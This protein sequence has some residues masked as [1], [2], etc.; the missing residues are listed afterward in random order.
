MNKIIFFLLKFKMTIIVLMLIVILGFIL[1]WEVSKG[2]IN[3]SMIDYNK[4]NP[5][6]LVTDWNA[7]IKRDKI[8]KISKWQRENLFKWDKIRTL[9]K[10]T[11]T[12]FWPDW[13]ITRLWERS[14][15]NIT[16]LNLNKDTTSNIKFDIGSWKSWSNIVRYMDNSTFTETYDNERL[17][18]TVRWTIFEINVDRDYVHSVNHSVVINDVANNKDYEVPEWKIR[19][20]TWTL[21]FLTDKSLENAWEN[22][23]KKEDVI[24][25]NSLLIEWRKKIDSTV[26]DLKLKESINDLIDW[27]TQDIWWIKAVLN[28]SLNDNSKKELNKFFLNLYQN[29]N[30][31]PNNS[32]TIQLKANLRDEIINSS[33]DK[34]R[35][36]YINDFLRLNLFDY[37]DSINNNFSDSQN[38][39][40]NYINTYA[41]KNLDKQYLRSV[42]KSIPEDK[43]KQ[44]NDIF[45]N[46]NSPV[47][48]IINELQ[49]PEL[50]EKADE[51]VNTLKKKA[52]DTKNI[53]DK[54]ATEAKDSLINIFKNKNE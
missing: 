33:N 29:I 30:N 10:T 51:D 36:R 21:D 25:I 45:E 52:L 4:V 27:K 28:N 14:S 6:I 5:Y 17:A 11:A 13:S 37:I 41:Q 23:N 43:L 31:I 34:D 47:K 48:N 19:K 22:W 32:W 8:I 53:I 54:K 15:I 24:Y 7:I 20:S 40:K 12:L 42:L 46:I 38:V 1:S 3:A 16:D 35:P 18:A 9:S 2:N 50:K 49:N 44:I 26:K 39:L